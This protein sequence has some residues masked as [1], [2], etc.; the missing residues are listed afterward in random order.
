MLKEEFYKLHAD[1]CRTIFNTRRLVIIDLLR[2]KEMSVK[3]LTKKIDYSQ[4]NLSQHLAILRAKGVLSIRR[5]GNSNY[6]S[7]VNPRIIE[8]VNLISEI[9]E[10]KLAN[11]SR[12]IKKVIKR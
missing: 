3:E 8:A 1:L 4:S 2:N 9:L 12:T 11:D 7:I 10:E 6:Y 5:E